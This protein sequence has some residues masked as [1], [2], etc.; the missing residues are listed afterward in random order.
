MSQMRNNSQSYSIYNTS[1]ELIYY[2]Y[3]YMY[4]YLL[5]FA[6]FR[7]EIRNQKKTG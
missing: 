6:I 4:I 5:K 3:T 2:I 1:Y 7:K